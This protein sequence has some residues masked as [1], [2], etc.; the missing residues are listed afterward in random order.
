MKISQQ[1]IE[2]IKKHEG[3]RLEAYRCAGGRW[4][5]GYGH[6]LT[7]RQNMRIDAQEAERLLRNDLTATESVVNA[8]LPN[9]NQHQFDALV[10][11]VFNVGAR[12]FLQSTLLIKI[13]QKAPANEIRHEFTRWSSAGGQTLPGL[14]RRRNEE[15]DLFLNHAQP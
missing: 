5:I 14:L 10:S 12:A 9:L 1:G 7:A 11:F 15:A 6:T 13:R 2:L 8:A 3:L 4:T